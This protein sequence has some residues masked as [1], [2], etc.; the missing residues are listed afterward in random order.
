MY[1]KTDKSVFQ[2]NMMQRTANENGASPRLQ[3]GFQFG[4]YL[5]FLRSVSLASLFAGISII[6]SSR[7]IAYLWHRI[8]PFTLI[9]TKAIL[10]TLEK[11]S[12][13]QSGNK[14]S[15]VATT[16]FSSWLCWQTFNAMSCKVLLG[17]LLLTGLVCN[18]LTAVARLS[19]RY[20]AGVEA[21]M[22]IL[23][24]THSKDREKS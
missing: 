15:S 3:F 8:S 13:L 11:L 17:F 23:Q 12:L 19:S 2:L 18:S 24:R 5:S 7:E 20:S 22:K 9:R 4:P 6:D 14:R 21:G 1:F 16:L 10:H